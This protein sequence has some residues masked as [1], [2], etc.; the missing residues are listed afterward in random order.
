MFYPS[1]S[2]DLGRGVHIFC[3]APIFWRCNACLANYAKWYFERAVSVAWM[4]LSKSDSMS[5]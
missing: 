1:F 3:I 4:M 5:P 2:G